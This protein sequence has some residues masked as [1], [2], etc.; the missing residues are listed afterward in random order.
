MTSTPP[1]AENLAT[2]RLHGRAALVTGASHG[3]GRATALLLAL[4]GAVVVATGRDERALASLATEARRGGGV[5]HPHRADLT[6]GD[7]RARLADI[8]RRATGRVSILVHSA[9]VHRSDPLAYAS[10]ARFDEQFAVNVHAPYALTQRLLPEL[11]AACGDIVFINSTQG[12]SASAGVSQYA[13]TKHALRAVADALRAEAAGT[14]VRVSTIFPGRTATPM[15][16]QIFRNE[17]RQWNPD[18]LVQPHD[19]ASLVVTAVALPA[20]AELSEV[21]IRPACKL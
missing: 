14:G 17:G 21:V 10:L 15:Q 2:H 16:E 7:E 13:A 4:E 19:I 20:R 5:V 8:A 11:T 18:L 6:D 1:A 9:G 12:I 3:I